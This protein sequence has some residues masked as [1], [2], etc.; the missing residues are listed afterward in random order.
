MDG[1]HGPPHAAL[2]CVSVTKPLLVLVQ[3]YPV[4]EMHQPLSIPLSSP[5][6]CCSSLELCSQMLLALPSVPACTCH[7]TAQQS[8]IVQAPLPLFLLL[9]HG[10]LQMHYARVQSFEL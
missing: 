3:H 7:A 4:F 5:L 1:L 10:G 6:A 8:Y 2:F 9:L